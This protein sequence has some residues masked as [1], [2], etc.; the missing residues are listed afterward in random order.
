MK[1]QNSLIS[2]SYI[3]INDNPLRV[4]CH[5]ILY[6]LLKEPSQKLRADILKDR[7]SDTFGLSMPQQLINNC[8]RILEK[9]GEVIHLPQ[10]AGYEISET[11]FDIDQF[12]NTIQRLHEHEDSLLQALISFVKGQYKKDWTKDEARNYLSSFLGKEGYGA[13]LFLQRELKIEGTQISPS[14]YIG[15]YINSIQ[16]EPD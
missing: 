8:I 4:F 10:G 12:E 15:R 6:L 16:Q 2:L 3:K 11:D 7:L 1:N 5:Y 13:Q 9:N 14:V